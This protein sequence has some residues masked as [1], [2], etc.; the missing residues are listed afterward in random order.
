MSKKNSNVILKNVF[1]ESYKLTEIFL[2]FKNKLNNL[3]T[4]S[5]LVAISGGP[6]SLALASLCKAYSYDYRCKFHYVLVNHNIRKN[7]LKEAKI[8]K[9][10]L[11]DK[12]INLTV[13]SNQIPIK[14][15]IQSTARNIRYKMLLEYC[16]KKGVKKI[17]TAHNL[18]DQVETFFIRL[19]RGSGLTGLSAMKPLTNLKHN[20]K[21]Y[22]PLLDTKK[23]FLI[24]ISKKTFG[25]FIKDPSNKNKKYLRTKIR[26]LKEP[27]KQS[28]IN[29]DQIINSINNLASSKE[30]LD[31]LLIK[32]SKE[33]TR[34]F[35]GNIFINLS[36]FNDYNKEFKLRLINQSIKMIKK[37]YYNPRSKKVA[38][39]IE[40]L[41]RPNFKKY[42]LGG[43]IFLR[44]KDQICVKSEKK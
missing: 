37:N 27:L 26:S 44:E 29:Y 38:R 36:K 13:L 7:S 32:A 12:K 25:S 43:C 1:K 5:Y 19:S 2:N 16:K 24:E 15:N 39:L 21:L 18:E 40:M 22:R 8:V 33:T 4:K 20:V 9:K 41:N 30:T 3:K 42:T 11:K 23:K 17:I 34:K 28:G 31:S 14:K 10:I 35:K 6:D